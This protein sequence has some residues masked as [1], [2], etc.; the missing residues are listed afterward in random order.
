MANSFRLVSIA[1]I[2]ASTVMPGQLQAQPL[3]ATRNAIHQV[4]DDELSSIRGRYLGANMLVGLRIELLSHWQDPSGNALGANATV[5]MQRDASG[6]VTLQVGTAATATAGAQPAVAN[7]LLTA[8]GANDVHVSGLSQISQVA[9]DGNT[10]LNLLTLETAPTLS[11]AGVGAGGA[12][13]TATAGNLEARVDFAA[14]GLQMSLVGPQGNLAQQ[15]GAN[16]GGVSQRIGI[17]GDGQQAINTMS[18]QMQTAPITSA[19][20]SQ[21]GVGGAL[22]AMLGL[23][24]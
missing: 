22:G 14:S 3:D 10:G 9:G 19:M 17:A 21:L 7:P 13:S 11:Q 8:S 18:I 5:L 15:V 6:Q 12:A 4:G 20:Q 16:A 2:A 1:A 24:H 23:R